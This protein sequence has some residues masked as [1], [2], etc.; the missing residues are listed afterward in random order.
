MQ[1]DYCKEKDLYDI[2]KN[3]IY[4]LK[5]KIIKNPEIVL[6]LHP[7]TQESNE[8]I[9][10]LKKHSSIEVTN[11][12]S[13]KI[14]CQ[15]LLFEGKKW[16]SEYEKVKNIKPSIRFVI[17]LQDFSKEYSENEEHEYITEIGK[18]V[19]ESKLYHDNEM[20]FIRYEDF[21]KEPNESLKYL[22]NYLE[23]KPF[24]INLEKKEI[25]RCINDCNLFRNNIWYFTIFYP[26][27]LYNGYVVEKT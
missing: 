24:E 4:D 11:D 27:F 18:I 14:Q 23:I 19:K 6:L 17:I 12:Y 7:H 21:T 1:S 9:E 22:T 5:E 2:I 15:I 25:K 10:T 13:K 3:D 16:F 20:F 26:D 8:V